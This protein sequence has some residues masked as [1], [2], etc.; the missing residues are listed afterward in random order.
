MFTG[1]IE[2]LGELKKIE[3]EEEIINFT[4]YCDF[5]NELKVDQSLAHNGVCLTVISINNDEYTVT[6]IIVICVATNTI[7]THCNH[8]TVNIPI[9]SSSIYLLLYSDSTEMPSYSINFSIQSTGQ[10]TTH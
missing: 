2:G 9:Y 6:A 10:N 8:E 5:T 1:I 4:F 3:K 7:P